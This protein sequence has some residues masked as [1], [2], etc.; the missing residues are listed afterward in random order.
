MWE[1][2]QCPQTKV[3]LCQVCVEAGGGVLLLCSGEG[4]GG[5]AMHGVQAAKRWVVLGWGGGIKA[6]W[7]TAR[8]ASVSSASALLCTHE[9]GSFLQVVCLTLTVHSSSAPLSVA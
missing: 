5:Q 4:C 2:I 3:P 1:L 7:C 9:P 6:G 8:W